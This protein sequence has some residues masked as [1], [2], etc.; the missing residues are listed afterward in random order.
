M[1]RMAYLARQ[2]RAGFQNRVRGSGPI[3]AFIDRILLWWLDF[4]MTPGRAIEFARYTFVSGASLGLDLVVFALLIY[5]GIF[6]V[7]IAGAVSVMAGLVLHYILSVTFVFDPTVT[8]KSDR[9][10]LIEYALTGAMG[11]A[12]TATSIFLVVNVLALPA[13]LGKAV[14]IGATF[15]SVYIVR[16]GFVFAPHKRLS[17]AE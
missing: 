17:G 1:L 2:M 10:L 8:G 7:A 6:S 16:A 9:Q 11:F 13:W 12:I 4:L 5:A 14:G 3:T 15:V